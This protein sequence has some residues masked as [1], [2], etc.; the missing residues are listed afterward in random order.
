MARIAVGAYMVRYPLGG[1]LSM[2]LQLVVGLDRLG[3]DVVVVEK[4]GWENACFDPSRGEMTNDAAHGTA[5]VA[6]LLAG[7]GLGEKWCFV[8]QQGECHGLSARELAAA[9]ARC[10]AFV[11]AGTHG[12]WLDDLTE[13][14][15]TVLLNGEPGWTQMRWALD[16]ADGR[17]PPDYDVYCTVGRNVGSPRSAIPTLGRE[18]RHFYYPVLID[19]F[20][21]LPSDADAPFTTV[22]NWRAHETLV[23]EGRAYGQKDVE[24]E[25]FMELPRL[26]GAARFDLA[27]AGTGIPRERL[28]A[29]GWRLRDAHEATRSF[30]AYR[31][32]VRCSRGEFSVA[33]NVFVETNSGWFGD[34]SAVYLASGRPVVLQDTGFS[35]HLPCGEGLFAVSDSAEAAA[36]VDEIER[37]YAR[38]SRAA[39]AIAIEFLSTDR[40]LPAFVREIG[41]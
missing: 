20:E 25:H 4:S 41:L 14:T 12:V 27:V 18:W 5:V 8:D 32:F 3:H 19:E 39:R 33:K 2:T 22:M 6:A 37:D 1:M 29:A 40:V 31:D 23:F 21:P 36:A 17:P 10:D 24:F 7:Y 9:L 30:G 34:R 13:G 11:D 28:E 15:R 16:E 26:A 38:H 35:E